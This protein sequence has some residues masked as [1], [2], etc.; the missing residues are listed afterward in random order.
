MVKHKVSRTIWIV[1]HGARA[2]FANGEWITWPERPDD[3]PLSPNGMLQAEELANFL[4]RQDIQHIFVSPYLR[5][6]QTIWPTARALSLPIKVE[7][8]LSE[9]LWKKTAQPQFISQSEMRQHFPLVDEKY[10]SWHPDLA[11]PET[12]EIS[13]QRGERVVQA[14]VEQY[15]GNL[16]LLGHGVTVLGAVRGLV[17][18]AHTLQTSFAAISRVEQHPDGWKLVANGD[19]SHLSEATNRDQHLIQL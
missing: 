12:E 8:G 15:D 2:D 18:G 3:P 14:L 5:T 11:G 10:R 17:G 19:T 1:R 9:C 13:H 6:L 7:T 16:L 4:S